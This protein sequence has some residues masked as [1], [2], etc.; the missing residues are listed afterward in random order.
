MLKEEVKVVYAPIFDSHDEDEL[1]GCEYFVTTREYLYGLLSM[2]YYEGEKVSDKE[3]H[4]FVVWYNPD[5]DGEFL[6]KKT[7]EDAMVL[8]KG[9]DLYI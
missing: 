2:H 4:R 1:A 9:Y 7:E 5:T 6:L 8:Y 3:W